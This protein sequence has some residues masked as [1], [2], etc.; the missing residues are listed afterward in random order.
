[1]QTIAIILVSVIPCTSVIRLFS[2]QYRAETGTAF[3]ILCVRGVLGILLASMLLPKLSE[4]NRLSS[5]LLS[6][7][8][9]D[10]GKQTSEN[11]QLNGFQRIRIN[12]GSIFFFRRHTA[13]RVICQIF[14]L[15][16]KL[17]LVLKS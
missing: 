8:K 12:F 14:Y 6:N 9:S 5:K 11:Q 13:M 3:I 4:T 2:G 17:T 7:W 10:I 15:I 1:M 16:G